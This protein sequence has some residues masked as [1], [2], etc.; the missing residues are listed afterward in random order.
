[1]NRSTKI[2]IVIL[3]MLSMALAG[4]T[5]GPAKAPTSAGMVVF[6][7][8]ATQHTATVML[9]I[10]PTKVYDA[11]VRVVEGNP[12]LE[13]INNNHDAYLLEVRRE[14][15]SVTAQATTMDRV[16]T[17]LFIWADAGDSGLTGHDVAK[18]AMESICGELKVECKMQD[19]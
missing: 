15:I 1:M 13:I 19:I 8:G 17:I 18:R 9:T 7:K 14:S 16:S 4:C 11:M 5:S 12:D 10:Q 2:L 3:G 6:A